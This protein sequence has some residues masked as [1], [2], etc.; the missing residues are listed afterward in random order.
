[1]DIAHETGKVSDC[2]AIFA[3]TS[4]N[5]PGFET[6]DPGKIDDNAATGK[7]SALAFQEAYNLNKTELGTSQDD[8][9]P[10]GSVGRKTW[11][12]IFDVYQFNMADEL[13][14]VDDEADIDDPLKKLEGLGKLRGL[15]GFLPTAKPF[16]GFGEKVP[17]NGIGKDNVA[18]AANRRVEMLFFEQGQEP[19]VGILGEAPEVSEL[20]LPGAYEKAELPQRPGG[21]KR[22]PQFALRLLDVNMKA[23]TDSDVEYSIRHEDQIVAAG[24]TTDGW[25]QFEVPPGS[26]S[27]IFVSWRAT[28]D[29]VGFSRWISLDSA[30][31]AD[32]LDVMRARLAA[33]GYVAEAQNDASLAQMATLYQTAYQLGGD[34]IEPGTLPSSVSDH[35]RK[36]FRSEFEA[37]PPTRNDS[38]SEEDEDEQSD[39]SEA[40]CQE[41]HFDAGLDEGAAT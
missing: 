22:Y 40:G 25:A 14:E 4:R 16:L 27:E 21:A 18:S 32:T 6:T 36:A 31:E 26:A 30:K 12:A 41:G 34:P 13:A 39:F 28:Q 17:V 7:P 2:K 35:L 10:D 1:V 15:V 8:L 3:W 23:I 24:T 20:N 19:D 38:S 11:G 37:P 9:K 5:I 29:A 33:L